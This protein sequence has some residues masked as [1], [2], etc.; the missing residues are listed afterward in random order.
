MTNK[1]AISA[2]VL[3]LALVLCIFEIKREM[4]AFNHSLD[5]FMP[6][7]DL[8]QFDSVP[9]PLTDDDFRDPQLPLDDF[10]K[11]PGGTN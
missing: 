2:T 5:E 8:P 3:F 10:S 11:L 6:S 7:E 4:T 1:Y 9:I